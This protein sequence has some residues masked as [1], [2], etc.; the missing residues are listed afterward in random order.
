MGR[1]VRLQF[2]NSNWHDSEKKENIGNK[3][4]WRPQSSAKP[5]HEAALVQKNQHIAM[6][7]KLPPPLES[8][9]AHPSATRHSV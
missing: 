4:I 3:S 2:G 7:C 9:L 6:C 5:L 1:N 8:Q